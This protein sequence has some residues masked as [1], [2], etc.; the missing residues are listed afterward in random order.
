MNTN[1]VITIARQCSTTPVGGKLTKCSID[2]RRI[3]TIQ[4]MIITLRI[5][6]LINLFTTTKLLLIAGL[7]CLSL[8]DPP[9]ISTHTV[10]SLCKTMAKEERM[11]VIQTPIG[12]QEVPKV[13]TLRT[14]VPEEDQATVDKFITIVVNNTSDFTITS[15]N[16]DKIY[17]L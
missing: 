3:I 6:I 1:R 10:E 7:R 5:T 14:R 2:N 16:F 9:N 15:N 4:C 11:A 13:G 12:L 17:N 8:Q